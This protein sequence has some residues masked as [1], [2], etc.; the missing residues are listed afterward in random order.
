MARL[1]SPDEDLETRYARYHCRAVFRQSFHEALWALTDQER[2]L[3]REHYLHAMTI[4]QV[5]RLHG[6]HRMTATRWMARQFS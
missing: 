3:L 2:L 4:G 1:P 6:V 5:A